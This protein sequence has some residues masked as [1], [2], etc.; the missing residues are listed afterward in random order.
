MVLN[1]V[2]VVNIVA[3]PN[4]IQESIET[5]IKQLSPNNIAKILAYLNLVVRYGITIHSYYYMRIGN[6]GRL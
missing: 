4:F 3:M 5:Q 6:F 1:M 2:K